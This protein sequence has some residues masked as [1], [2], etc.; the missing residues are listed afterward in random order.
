M[1]GAWNEDGKGP[2][3]WD[4]LTHN[5]PELIADHLTADIGPDSYHHY[6]DD[7]EALKQVG[8]SQ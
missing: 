1:L 5:H 8:V 6:K 3:I 4:T 2:S 7:I